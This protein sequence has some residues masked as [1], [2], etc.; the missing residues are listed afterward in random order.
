M[1]AGGTSTRCAVVG[2]DGRV[3]DRGRGA[4]GNLRS[5]SDS[6]AALHRALEGALAGVERR[7]VLAGHLAFAGAAGQDAA[8]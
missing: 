6:A 4:G 5:S 1:D 7:R 2:L 8:A 3:H